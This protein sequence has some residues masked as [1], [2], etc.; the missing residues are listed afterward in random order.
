VGIV[1]GALNPY[2][3][4]FVEMPRGTAGLG[5]RMT[6]AKIAPECATY[7]QSGLWIA[8]DVDSKS[9]ILCQKV[10][11]A[12]GRSLPC[13]EGL[14]VGVASRATTTIPLPNLTRE[15]AHRS[16]GIV[17]PNSTATRYSARP[18]RID[19]DVEGY[20]HLTRSIF[21]AMKERRAGL[22]RARRA[23]EPHL[24]ALRIVHAQLDSCTVARSARSGAMA[25]RR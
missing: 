5:Q 12:Y 2:P 6:G 11:A 23:V 15:G 19:A 9:L 7:M 10:F 22:R 17:V 18:G 16:C 25:A 3:V 21:H 8:K 24:P 13:G 14:G 1:D 4:S 20:G